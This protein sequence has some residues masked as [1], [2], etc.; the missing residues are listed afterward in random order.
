[1]AGRFNL[2]IKQGSTLKPIVFKF[3]NTIVLSEA[4]SIGE[5]SIE[6][7]PLSQNVTSGTTL[8]FGTTAVVTSANAFIGDRSISVV[9][10]TASLAKG[11]TAKGDPID[12]TGKSARAQ[13]RQQFSDTAPLASFT[14]AIASPATLGE[15]SISLPSTTSASLPA[16][17]FPDRADDIVD[18]QS[19]TFP[20]STESKLFLP[21]L[22]PFYFDLEI[23]DTSAPPVVDRYI[24]GRV[25]VTAEATR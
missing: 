10:L 2:L 8:T 20:S 13:I 16:N 24:Y 15:V 22:A 12:L 7:S 25:V 14:C 1:M 3:R 17:I 6:V 5:E 11:V 18:L 21:G 4:A 9:A 23:F 19:S